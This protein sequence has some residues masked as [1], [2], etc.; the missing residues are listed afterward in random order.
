MYLIME[1]KRDFT[2]IDDVV[3]S[4]QKLFQNTKKRF[5]YIPNPPKYKMYNVGNNNQS[6]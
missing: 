1:N 4:I 5:Q 6:H 3:E 2:Y